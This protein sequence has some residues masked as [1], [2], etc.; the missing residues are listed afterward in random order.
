MRILFFKKKR[1]IKKIK[2]FMK[3]MNMKKLLIYGGGFDPVHIGHINLLKNAIKKI[4]PD[5]IF[6]V[7]S[8]KPLLSNKIN[9]YAS[10]TDRLNMC[11]IAFSKLSKKIYFS[12]F[13]N[14]YGRI[15]TYQLIKFLRCNYSKYSLFLLL[16]ADR[17]NNLKK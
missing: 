17:A 2:L 9:H 4:N 1:K 8:K 10:F 11:K 13:E 15:Y 16:G 12:D 3:K 14:K 6:V 7:P 5:L